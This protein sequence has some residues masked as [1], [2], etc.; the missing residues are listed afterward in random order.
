MPVVSELPAPPV[1]PPLGDPTLPHEQ[2]LRSIYDSTHHRQSYLTRCLNSTVGRSSIFTATIV[3]FNLSIYGLVNF[4]K[5]EHRESGL[6]LT[7]FWLSVLVTLLL[8]TI[9]LLAERAGMTARETGWKPYLAMYRCSFLLGCPT[10]ALMILGEGQKL[11]HGESVGSSGEFLL[12]Q[13]PNK[14]WSYFELKDG[15]VALN[16]TKGI[17]ETLAAAEHGPPE[18]KRVSR[19][20]DSELRINYE[21]YSDV[22]EPTETPGTLATYRIAPVFS[23]WAYCTTRYR[24]ST[25]CLRQNPVKAWAISKSNSICSTYN[26]VS[27]R[28]PKPLLEPL[29]QCSDNGGTRGDATKSPI[30]GICGRVTKPPPDGAI[31]E[32]AALLLYDAWPS[33]SVPKP[34]DLWL[35]V[36]PDDCI[37]D[38]KSCE[39]TWSQLWLAGF[40]FQILTNILMVVPAIQDCMV[41]YKIRAARTFMDKQE[42]EKKRA[43][44]ALRFAGKDNLL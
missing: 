40:I 33:F 18:Y 10:L 7:Y 9:P 2:P 3:I 35:D 29:Y 24:I 5:P 14:Y 30:A 37:S 39:D 44:D 8:Y 16:L 1:V 19:F 15:F 17:T 11:W 32:L 4:N 34:T 42:T 22:P 27:C 41:D 36:S 12:D 25:N 31:D 43:M 20:R 23:D 6:S 21:P 38:P 13:V 28:P 26:S